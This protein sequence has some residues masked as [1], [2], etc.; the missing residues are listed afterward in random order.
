LIKLYIILETKILCL[1]K[2]VSII[3]KM[4]KIISKL[5]SKLAIKVLATNILD[6]KLVSERL[7][8]TNFKYKV[9]SS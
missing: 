5:V 1:S 7:I 8:E 2:V 6:Y 4:Y 9:V 3:N